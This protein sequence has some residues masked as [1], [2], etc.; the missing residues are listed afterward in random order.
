[1]TDKTTGEF[2]GTCGY[3]Y[4]D[5]DAKQVEIGYDVWKSYWGRDYGSEAVEM[6]VHDCFEELDVDH[7]YALIHPENAASIRLLEKL[8]FALSDP[9]RTIEAEPQVCL[10]LSR[11]LVVPI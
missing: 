3:H 5:F 4:L 2:I 10:K 6:H 1:M 9:C 11:S 7:I 8:G